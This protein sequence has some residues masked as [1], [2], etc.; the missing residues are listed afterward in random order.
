MTG[1]LENVRILLVRPYKNL[2]WVL[3]KSVR[4]RWFLLL[5]PAWFFFIVAPNKI[6]RQSRQVIFGIL[7]QYFNGFLL[8]CHLLLVFSVSC[9]EAE[10]VTQHDSPGVHWTSRARCHAQRMEPLACFRFFSLWEC[11]GD[12]MGMSCGCHDGHITWDNWL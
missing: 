9:G 8:F 5:K 2:R 3:A 10:L 12:N 4:N 6:Y 1:H 7:W 11:H